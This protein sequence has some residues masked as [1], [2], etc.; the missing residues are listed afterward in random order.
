MDW[1]YSV[2]DPAEQALLG[3]LSVFAGGCTLEALDAVCAEGDDVLPQL[4]GL[5]DKSFVNRKGPDH[6]PRFWLLETVREYALERLD[7]TGE[8]ERMHARHAAY[9]LVVAERAEPEL[10]GPQQGSWLDRLEAD[11]DNCRAALAW[12]S[13]ADVALNLRLAAALRR[14]WHTRGYLDEGRRWLAN[15]LAIGTEAPAWIR[16]KVLNCAAALEMHEGLRD[17]TRPLLEE[18][19]RLCRRIGDLEGAA[20]A[21]LLLAQGARDAGDDALAVSLFEESESL[22]RR[23]GSERGVVVVLANLASLELYRGDYERAAMRSEESVRLARG[24]GDKTLLG[25]SLGNHGFAL[26]NAG[27][28]GEATAPLRESLAVAHEIG[29]K[30]QMLYGLIG[31]AAL[32]LAVGD[33]PRAAELLGAAARLNDTIAAVLS[34]FERRL[35]ESTHEGARARLGEQSFAAA[36]M[37]GQ[38]HELEEALELAHVS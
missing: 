7:E 13:A 19:L 31:L 4:G 21:L 37:R 14:F 3:K 1:S 22:Y 6:E 25:V 27:R 10:T 23:R 9:F 24:I 20:F 28:Y 26:L 36:W 2:L 5:L 17:E 38:R 18:S 29:F 12:S 11:H 15:A 30:E 32:E 35:Y 16:A 33:C 34:P 8:L